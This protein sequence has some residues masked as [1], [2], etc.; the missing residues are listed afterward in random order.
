[1][2]AA[3]PGTVPGGAVPHGLAM[4]S[5]EPNRQ[6]MTLARGTGAVGEKAA[7]EGMPDHVALVHGLLEIKPQERES[8]PYHIALPPATTTPLNLNLKALYAC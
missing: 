2:S 7:V 6:M 3:V 1:M 4:V 5:G 8:E